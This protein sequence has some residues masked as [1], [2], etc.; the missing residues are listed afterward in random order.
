[1][2]QLAKLIGL[3]SLAGTIVPPL[4]FTFH[5]MP[6]LELV[7]S[8]MFVSTIAWLITAPMWMKTN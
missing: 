5:V 7:K 6:S 3:L 1:M 8:S 2:I 4:L